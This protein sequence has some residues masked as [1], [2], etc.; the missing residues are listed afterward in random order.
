[1]RV[2]RHRREGNFQQ[3]GYF[4]GVEPDPQPPLVWLLAPGLRF[5]SS[6]DTLLKYLTPE[7][8]VTRI[9]RSENWRRGLKL[10]FRQ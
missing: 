4:N 6:T 2:R 1:M 3:F 5:D 7:I 8:H 10:V 9:G